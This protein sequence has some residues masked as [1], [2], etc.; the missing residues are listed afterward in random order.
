[1]RHRPLFGTVLVTIVFLANN[2]LHGEKPTNYQVLNAQVD[3][4]S[5]SVVSVIS[6]EGAKSVSLSTASRSIDNFVRQRLLEKLLRD[7]IQV[8]SDSTVSPAIRIF[9]PLVEVTYSAP[10]A[11]HIFSSSDVRRTVRSDYDV[12][13]S[14]GARINFAK[15]FSMAFSDTVSESE[16]P[17]LEAG[18]YVFLHG[19]IESRSV[20]DTILQPVLFVAS[21]AVIVYLFFTLRGS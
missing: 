16:I 12:E 14:D 2:G 19:R 1:M 7:K 10:V 13:I 15:T 11:S 8:T 3:S 5:V 20:L 17:D 18:S 9:V 21:A 4:L 6:R